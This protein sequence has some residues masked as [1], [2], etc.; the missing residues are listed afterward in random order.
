M[1][2]IKRFITCFSYYYQFTLHNGRICD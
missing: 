2:I 1:F